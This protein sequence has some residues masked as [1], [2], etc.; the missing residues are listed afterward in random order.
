MRALKGRRTVRRKGKGGMRG[1][2][3]RKNESLGKEKRDGR[4]NGKKEERKNRVK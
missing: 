2:K 1:D 4:K 3:V